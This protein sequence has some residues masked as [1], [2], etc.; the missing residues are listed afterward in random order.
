MSELEGP[1]LPTKSRTEKR[2]NQLPCCPPGAIPFLPEDPHYVPHGAMVSYDGA[3]AYQVGS[4]SKSLI[5]AHDLF[6]LPS[7]L[8]KYVCDKFAEGLPGY[9]IIAPDF[10][11]H[12]LL[13]GDDPLIERGGQIRNKIVW[14]VVSC[15]I[16]GYIGKCSWENS[17]GQVFNKT[18]TYLKTLGVGAI[19]LQGNCWGGY[20]VM[21]ACN[22]ADDIDLI[23]AALYAHPS[24]HNL[25]TYYKEDAMN[26]VNGV[27]CPQF[28][29]TTIDEPASWKPHGA[30]EEALSRKSFGA[31]CEF[32]EYAERHGFFTRGD[33]TKELTRAAIEDLLNKSIKFIH[34][35]IPE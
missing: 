35:C 16:C 29:A 3:E 21:K 19:A 5:F 4:G 34:K 28:I 32:Y 9:I 25:A 6:G 12:G 18:T 13:F 11:P 31:D 17:A 23:K 7:G 10:F 30:V 1:L 8:N 26:L 24:V 33:T 14:S 27:K 15:K 2:D 22:E 20:L